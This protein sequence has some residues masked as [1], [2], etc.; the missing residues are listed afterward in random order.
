MKGFKAKLQKQMKQFQQLRKD[1]LNIDCFV[2]IYILSRILIN[3]YI[4]INK[5]RNDIKTLS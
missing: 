5:N 3:K 1:L 4:V 2:E